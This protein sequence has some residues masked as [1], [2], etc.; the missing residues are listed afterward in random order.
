MKSR[1]PHLCIICGDGDG[2]DSLPSLEL[3]HHGGL[4][5]GHLPRLLQLHVVVGQLKMYRYSVNSGTGMK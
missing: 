5:A 4:V 2:S 3:L 1:S